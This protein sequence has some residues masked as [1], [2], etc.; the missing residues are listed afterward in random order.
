MYYEQATCQL[1]IIK[2]RLVVST[3]TFL[4]GHGLL[5]Q[6]VMM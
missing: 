6:N 5:Y 4:Q 1:Q 2:S 3:N